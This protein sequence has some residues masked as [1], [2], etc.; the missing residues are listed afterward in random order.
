MKRTMILLLAVVEEEQTD[1]PRTVD[2][3]KPPPSVPAKPSL[4]K[5]ADVIPLPLRRRA[6]GR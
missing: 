6:V 2:T 3:D 1:T 5:C 4:A